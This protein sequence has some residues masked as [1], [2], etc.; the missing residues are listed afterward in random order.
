MFV[1][2]VVCV[3]MSVFGWVGMSGWGGRRVTDYVT[4]CRSMCHSDVC[5][6]VCQIQNEIIFLICLPLV[7]D[8]E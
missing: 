3:C 8:L 7:L 1:N 4:A 2:V 5:V 6:R